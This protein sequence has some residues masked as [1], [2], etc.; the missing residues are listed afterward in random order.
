MPYAQTDEDNRIIN[1]SYEKLDGM[2][3]EFSNGDYVNENCV[4]GSEDFII[5]GGEAI[6]SPLPEKEIEQ[7]KKKLKDTDYVS[8][9]IAE[10]AATREEY[11][12][13]LALRQSWRDRINELEAL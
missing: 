6:Y 13:M 10:G 9:K 2:D 8:A 12:E 4:D 5:V 7:L 3:V 11:A 1:W